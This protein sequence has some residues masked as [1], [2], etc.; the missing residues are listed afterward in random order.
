[1]ETG[2]FC[3][4]RFRLIARER[5]LMKDGVR[6]SLGGR[7]LDL[8]L[9]LISR[10]GETVNRDDLFTLVWPDVI[11]SKTNLRVHIAAVRKVLG[12]G[13]DGNRFIINVSGRGYRFV[14]PVAQVDSGAAAGLCIVDLSSVDDSAK[15]TTA[16]ASALGCE[17]HREPP[18][19]SV[20]AHLR[21]KRMLL[22][23]ENCGHV[24]AGVSQ[25]TRR[26]LTGAPLVQVL[27]ANQ[28]ASHALPLAQSLPPHQA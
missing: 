18:L 13:R 9:A 1:M 20:L 3:F 10:A 8:L 7:A 15:V 27:V 12:D 21:E 19:T 17:L 25:L 11:V 4:G 6:V 16:V 23:F 26:L 24:F 14:A 5:E 22:A 28:Q 2:I